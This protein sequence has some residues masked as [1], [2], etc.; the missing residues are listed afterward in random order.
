MKKNE[1][2]KF[3]NRFDRRIAVHWMHHHSA[4]VSGAIFRY[5]A[6]GV[7]FRQIVVSR[8]LWQSDS[9]LADK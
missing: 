7:V 3:Q 9:E 8:L 2:K 5:F 4:T 1:M 6:W